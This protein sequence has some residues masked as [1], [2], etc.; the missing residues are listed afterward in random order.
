MFDIH[1]MQLLPPL[2][3]KES[4]NAVDVGLRV[5]SGH[6]GGQYISHIQAQFF[7][8]ASQSLI[9]N[10]IPFFLLFPFGHVTYWQESQPLLGL[11]PKFEKQWLRMIWRRRTAA[12]HILNINQEVYGTTVDQKLT[13][14]IVKQETIKILSPPK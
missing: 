2:A 7:S 8:Q 4:W 14:C 12:V 13:T 1:D 10:F 6:L 9:S 5:A 11:D 3:T